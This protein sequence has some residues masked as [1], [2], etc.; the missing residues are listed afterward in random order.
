MSSG[1]GAG[2]AVLGWL[3]TSAIVDVDN[4][5]I[6]PVQTVGQVG[7]GDRGGRRG[8]VE[9]ELASAP[10]APPGRSARTPPRFS[11]PPESTRS[12]RLTAENSS[13]TR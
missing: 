5:Q 12:P 1:F 9:H 11:A 2:S 10:R 7:G 4:R 13:A 8:V 6:A 3:S